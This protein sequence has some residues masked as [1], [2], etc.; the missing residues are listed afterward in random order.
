MVTVELVTVHTLELFEVIVTGSPDDAVADTEKDASP[1]VIEVREPKVIV[2]LAT[3]TVNVAALE[4]T[5]ETAAFG[6]VLR[7]TTR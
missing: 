3:F 1:Y 7:T 6:P 2:W 5:L 4:V